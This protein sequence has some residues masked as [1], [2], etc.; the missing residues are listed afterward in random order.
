M[1]DRTNGVAFARMAEHYWQ[2]SEGRDPSGIA[3]AEWASRQAVKLAPSEGLAWHYRRLALERNQ[4]WTE[5][6]TEAD[7]A[8]QVESANVFAWNAKAEAHL[9]M[10]QSEAALAACNRA[11]EKQTWENPRP[12]VP[13][14]SLDFIHGKTHAV[15]ILVSLTAEP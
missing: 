3:Q 15:P 2:Q 11:L 1:L 8:I 4:Q 9:E 7:Q 5:L 12:D 14:R 10:G 6:L 13:I